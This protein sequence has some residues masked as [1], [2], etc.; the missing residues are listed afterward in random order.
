MSTIPESADAGE[1]TR[2]VREPIPPLS[3]LFGYGPATIV[4]LLGLAGWLL[5]Q[6]LGDPAAAAGHLP[7]YPQAF[8]VTTGWLFATAI[9]LFLAGVTRGLSFFSPG[10]P[11]TSQFVM[12][13]WLFLLGFGALVTPMW[14]GFVLLI[15]GYGSIAVFD[16]QAARTGL[17]P[18]YFARLRPGQMAV[19]IGGLVLLLLRTLHA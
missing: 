14:I 13:L 17:A 19:F 3:I 12:M 10:G 9:L 8:A 5:P 15:L 18:G 2:D 16:P 11:H 6:T 4:L 1:P 7:V